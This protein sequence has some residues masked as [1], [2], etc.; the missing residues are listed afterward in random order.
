MSE[1]DNNVFINQETNQERKYHIYENL[2]PSEKDI[3]IVLLNE[4]TDNGIRGKCVDYPDC[5]I[6][7]PSTEINKRNV[8]VRKFFNQDKR[9][10]MYVLSVSAQTKI[11]DVS[12]KK[13]SEDERQEALCRFE[14]F[15]RI[16]NLGVEVID[17]L[18][19][20]SDKFDETD[21][22]LIFGAI[23]KHKIRTLIDKPIKVIKS[24]Y[25]EILE[26]PLLL[27]SEFMSSVVYNT[28]AHKD[29]LDKLM[30]NY[31]I[32]LH[33]RVHISR[34]IV[35]CEFSLV[36]TSND[37]VNKIKNI[38][39]EGYEVISSNHN[40]NNFVQVE[41]I[42]SPKYRFVANVTQISDA[43][44]L[45]TKASDILDQNC[46]KYGSKLSNSRNFVV[47]KER[48]YTVSNYN[49]NN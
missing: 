16:K 26:N 32:N 3:V 6:F 31:V 21:I 14:E 44:E 15:E 46:E 7:V 43:N 38:L 11:I 22:E 33:K 30:E 40:P 8:N 12:Y 48:Q 47:V 29:I 28:H 17:L 4:I 1:L 20:L 23:I 35:V 2:V 19:K 5:E 18:S 34:G 45:L 42:S 41:Y 49:R 9:Y 39:T 13:I 10:S 37:A 25:Y 27:F 24:I 36:V